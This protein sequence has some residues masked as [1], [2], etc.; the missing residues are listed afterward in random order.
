M[1]Y[2]TNT[3]GSKAVAVLPNCTNPVDVADFSRP[4][5]QRRGYDRICLVS[6]YSSQTRLPGTGAGEALYSRHAAEIDIPRSQILTILGR[7]RFKNSR[8]GYFLGKCWRSPRHFLKC[9][10]GL[11]YFPVPGSTFKKPLCC[12]CPTQVTLYCLFTVILF[13]NPS[14]RAGKFLSGV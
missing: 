11:V 6:G 9:L 12:A 3:F 2:A 10:A 5:C 8:M 14:A 13:T 1:G 4:R 7:A